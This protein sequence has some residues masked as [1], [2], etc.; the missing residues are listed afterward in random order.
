[1]RPSLQVCGLA[2]ARPLV[3]QICNNQKTLWSRFTKRTKN[4]NILLLLLRNGA[5]KRI[6]YSA[7]VFGRF[8][9]KKVDRAV[10]VGVHDCVVDL[11]VEWFSSEK[12]IIIL[13][14]YTK[15]SE[16][17]CQCTNDFSL[18][19]NAHASLHKLNPDAAFQFGRK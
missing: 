2:N 18:K 6:G 19:L 4:C 14:Q 8:G 3:L 16:V 11:H 5:R 7:G 13:L 17:A 12:T 9:L 1:M 15:H 10:Q